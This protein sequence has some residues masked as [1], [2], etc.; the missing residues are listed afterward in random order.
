MEDHTKHEEQV[1]DILAVEASTFGF[2]LIITW[3]D[4]AQDDVNIQ[5]II[6]TPRFEPVLEFDKPEDQRGVET[7]RAVKVLPDRKGVFW[8]TSSQVKLDSRTLYILAKIERG[9]YR[10]VLVMVGD[11]IRERRSLL[12][13]H[14]ELFYIMNRIENDYIELNEAEHSLL[15]L[16]SKVDEAERV[17]LDTKDKKKGALAAAKIMGWNKG[18]K[19]PKCS[20]RL[21]A[22]WYKEYLG[23][24][25]GLNPKEAMRKI[26]HD[27]GYPSFGAAKQ[28]V[29][30]GQKKCPSL[31]APLPADE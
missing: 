19:I 3:S 17:Y 29:K 1:P 28:S 12:L 16:R 2:S 10:M 7:F 9:D 23:S 31:R 4:G 11:A 27:F 30:R 18:E 15:S 26:Q 13:R 20:D 21:R 22:S 6:D 8:P 5:T 24:G 25:H 14:D